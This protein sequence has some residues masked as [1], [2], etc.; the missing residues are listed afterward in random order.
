MFRPI[1]IKPFYSFGKGENL[2]G[3]EVFI[4][5]KE[6]APLSLTNFYIMQELAAMYPDK[7]AFKEG[8]ADA[9]RFN[10]F[11]KVTGQQGNPPPILREP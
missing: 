4:T 2:Q 8:N 10:M 7:A 6:V 5:D 3:V 11:D 9:G 1:H